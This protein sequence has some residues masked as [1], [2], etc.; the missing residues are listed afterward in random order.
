MGLSVDHPPGNSFVMA[1]SYLS[2]QQT[3]MNLKLR[4]RHLKAW[5]VLL[6]T[7]LTLTSLALF[8]Q[9]IL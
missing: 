2:T 1:C 4:N 5:I 8:S 6:L 9:I 3:P 7:V